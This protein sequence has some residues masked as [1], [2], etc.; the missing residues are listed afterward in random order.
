M[1]ISCADKLPIVGER[2]LI[3]NGETMWVA[4]LTSGGYWDDGDFNSHLTD[5]TYWQPLPE[6][7]KKEIE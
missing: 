2:V 7:P 5:M 3:T 4:Y 6:L 1:W